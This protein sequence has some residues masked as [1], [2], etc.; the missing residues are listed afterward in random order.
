MNVKYVTLTGA[1]NRTSV[2]GILE[3]SE[4]FS[5]V[6]WGI[7]FSK[8]HQGENRYP[9]WRWIDRICLFPNLHLS[10][11]LCGK[12]AMDAMHGKLP[13]VDLENVDMAFGTIQLNY[14]SQIREVMNHSVLWQTISVAHN[15][16]KSV[17]LAG[18]YNG[19]SVDASKFINAG[20]YPLFDSGHIPKKWMAPYRTEHGTPLFCGYAGFTLENVSKELNRLSEVVGDVSI[21]IDVSFNEFDLKKCRQF[22]RMVKTYNDR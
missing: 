15:G 19:L 20:V 1:D 14:S 6:E 21:W 11:H 4:E 7:L 2:E 16:R 5:F 10:A 3:I 13:I 8:A 22:L 18:N 17:I 12:Y 9:S